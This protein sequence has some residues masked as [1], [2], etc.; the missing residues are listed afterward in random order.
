MNRAHAA[1]KAYREASQSY[2]VVCKEQVLI[3]PSMDLPATA[4]SVSFCHRFFWDLISDRRRVAQQAGQQQLQQGLFCHSLRVTE[5]GDTPEEPAMVFPGRYV[6]ILCSAD[7]VCSCGAA[8]AREPRQPSAGH[9]QAAL[10][11]PVR[12]RLP[13]RVPGA[14]G[15]R[16]RGRPGPAIQHDRRKPRGLLALTSSC[17]LAGCLRGAFKLV[18][19]V[20]VQCTLMAGHVLGTACV[21]LAA[22]LPWR[23]Q[24]TLLSCRRLVPLRSCT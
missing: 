15:S 2:E 22:L 6:I 9:C 21:P 7:L 12:A 1:K 19:R 5:G 4:R 16:E 10:G 14:P 8:G 17:G 3:P 18:A 20:S 11:P 24:L 23:E 13:G